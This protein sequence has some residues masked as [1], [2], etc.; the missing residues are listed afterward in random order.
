MS[1]MS[2]RTSPAPEAHT[3][4]GGMLGVDAAGVVVWATR[5]A[6]QLLGHDDGE[7]VGRRWE[8]T[9]PAGLSLSLDEEG[10]VTV[11]LER[12]L[13]GRRLRSFIE[14]TDGGLVEH[15]SPAPTFDLFE[16]ALGALELA[17]RLQLLSTALSATVTLPEALDV[18]VEHALPALGGR[19]GAV[20]VLSRDR[21][22]LE[23]VQGTRSQQR[24]PEQFRRMPLALDS[25][26]GHAWTT[27]EAVWL[28]GDGE[29]RFPRS[30][31]PLASMGLERVGIVPMIVGAEP[32]GLLVFDA[33]GDGLDP[34]RKRYAQAIAQACAHA[35]ERARLAEE[36]WQ[37]Q[38]A[39][40]ASE[41][42]MRDITSAA[43]LLVWMQDP[44]GAISWINEERALAYFGV[45]LEQLSTGGLSRVHP[46]DRSS[47]LAVM[48]EAMK[49]RTSYELELRLRR[50]DGAFRW[51]LVRAEARTDEQTGQFHWYGSATDVDDQ[52]RTQQALAASEQRLRLALQA[53][54]MLA[55]EYDVESDVLT[56]T[57]NEEAT[58]IVPAGPRLLD[59]VRSDIHPDDQDATH[60]R[61]LEAVANDVDFEATFRR[62]F[63]DGTWHWLESRA[64]CIHDADGKVTGLLGV[65]RD[66]NEEKR[67]E[68][69]LRS[70]EEMFRTVAQT[71]PVIVWTNTPSGE[72]DFFNTRFWR[73]TG[74]SEEQGAGR[75][76]TI[77]Y[78]HPD[79]VAAMHRGIDQ[80]L[81]HGGPWELEFR[82]RRHDGTWRWHLGR[83]VPVRDESGELVLWVGS[84]TDIDDQKRV[85]AEREEL[86]ARTQ[87]AVRGREVFLAVAAHELRTPLTPLR[88]HVDTLLRAA[89]AGGELP[90]ARVVRGLEVA[91]RQI[92]RL[93][94]L[95]EALLDVSRIASGR[96]ELQCETLDL[97]QVASD[98]LDRH[99]H[100]GPP[101]I[102]RLSAEGNLTGWL[103]RMRVEQ[104]LTN[105]LTNAFRYG[106]RNPVHVALKDRGDM[107]RMSVRDQ[108]VGIA[109]ADKQRIFERF[110]R[111]GNHLP[112]GG[113]GLGL[114]IV[115][116]IV[117]AMGGTI[118]VESEV[119]RGSTF[120]VELP[121]GVPPES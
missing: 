69:R 100:E 81:R 118:D 107:L 101:E 117:V 4:R 90:V 10:D 115:H 38:A 40:A 19:S 54:R 11:E 106:Q 75:A 64:T 91:S 7:L 58:G 110:E 5:G 95:V 53:G 17:E 92:K 31:A 45:G 14:R 65:S 72:M 67:A 29:T 15:L 121:R 83:C 78:V 111:A 21:T 46:D 26:L 18:F 12:G 97:A 85:L 49:S 1:T 8:D 33:A 56:T 61:F 105:L 114:W 80:S 35:F 43:P 103:D 52:K 88:L 27:G 37:M 119:G 79:D 96:L 22:C 55:W 57:A 50:R 77:E 98:V 20:A 47:L 109:P 86:L 102:L 6:H 113:L 108:G 82:M 94:M 9:F 34:A 60:R 76:N 59:A 24:V 87:E 112:Q 44:S 32:V 48:A 16:E 3:V 39:V 2:H 89:A 62:R 63:A 25:A 36:E 71:L 93:Q 84:A 41:R 70:S 99:R 116:Q 74:R 51:H 104:I 42:R 73:Y 30:A 68:L 120:I 23:F 13:S 66:V 28:D